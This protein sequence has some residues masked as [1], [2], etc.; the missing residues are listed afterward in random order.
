GAIVDLAD[1]E[2]DLRDAW[3]HELHKTERRQLVELLFEAAG[4]GLKISI[5]SGDVHVSAAFRMS[6]GSSVIYQLTSSAITYNLA[7]PMGWALGAGVV[8]EGES[9]DG[10]HFKRLALY[11]ERNYALITVDAPQGKVEFQLYG[12]QSVSHPWG[13]TEDLPV[14]HSMMKLE[15]DFKV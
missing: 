13:A 3:E 10:Y 9:P 7:L 14:T 5:L 8:D 4:R 1:L 15:L 6:R 11:T 12:P 2:D